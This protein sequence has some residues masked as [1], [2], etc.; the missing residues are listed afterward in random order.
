MKCRVHGY[1][2][3]HEAVIVKTDTGKFVAV[4]AEW[5]DKLE[6]YYFPL[7]PGFCSTVLKFQGAELDH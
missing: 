3:A 4:V 2:T 7:R 6:R 5:D 1:D